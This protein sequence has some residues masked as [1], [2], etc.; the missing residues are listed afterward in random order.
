MKSTILL[1]AILK[2]AKLPFL[3]LGDYFYRRVWS[4]ILRYR[5]RKISISDGNAHRDNPYMYTGI[6]T[7]WDSITL[8]EASVQ[9]SYDDV[10]DD[11]IHEK[12]EAIRV[13]NESIDKIDKSRDKYSKG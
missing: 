3:S 4:K 7:G 5:V 10:A 8:N 6:T 9:F 11:L 2:D 1:E 13:L 12:E